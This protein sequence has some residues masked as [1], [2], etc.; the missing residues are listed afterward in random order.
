MPDPMAAAVSQPF[1]QRLQGDTTAADYQ[2]TE[3][4]RM[5]HPTAR[6]WWGVRSTRAG[7]YA[8]CYLCG[9]IIDAWTSAGFPPAR[10]RDTVLEHRHAEVV[11]HAMT[12]AMHAG[13]PTAGDGSTERRSS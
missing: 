3:S 5:L 6:W 12:M 13:G 1:A 10:V 8:A 9:I 2:L 11:R 7:K 4:A